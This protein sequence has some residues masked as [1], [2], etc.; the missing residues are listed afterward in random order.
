MQ[1]SGPVFSGNS[2]PR[3][4]TAQ[5]AHSVSSTD[6]DGSVISEAGSESWASS[7]LRC[8][9]RVHTPSLLEF[10]GQLPRPERVVSTDL[11]GDRVGFRRRF[12][13]AGTLFPYN[14]SQQT[15]SDPD[16]HTE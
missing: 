9:G 3:V 15:R 6:S 12:S 16:P 2:P 1:F 13:G 11:E 7:P 8:R 4:H 10:D 5:K 14:Y